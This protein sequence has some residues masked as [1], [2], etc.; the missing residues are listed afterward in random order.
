MPPVGC[1]LATIKSSPFFTMESSGVLPDASK[2]AVTSPVIPTASEWFG[3]TY[4][5]DA[6]AVEKSLHALIAKGEY[7][8]R[9][10][11]TPNP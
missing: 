2:D 10:W 5:E 11:N 6:P 8:E 3:V 9:L 7:P 1:W 4:K